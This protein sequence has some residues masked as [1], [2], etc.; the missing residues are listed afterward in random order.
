MK[1]GDVS[2]SYWNGKLEEIKKYCEGD[3]VATMN[4]MLKL[5]RLEIII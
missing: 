5:A 2:A 3:V 1:A 4:V